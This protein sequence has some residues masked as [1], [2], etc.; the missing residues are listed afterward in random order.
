MLRGWEINKQ[1]IT[2]RVIII[3]STTGNDVTKQKQKRDEI[4]QLTTNNGTVKS[5]E[6]GKFEFKTG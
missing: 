1:K 6:K 5:V 4:P 3:R 2:S